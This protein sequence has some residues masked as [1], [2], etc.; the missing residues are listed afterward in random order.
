MN[1]NENEKAIN[2]IMMIGAK[3]RRIK[4]EQYRIGR[5][6]YV[7]EID[8]EAGRVRVEW[9]GNPTAAGAKTPSTWVNRNVVELI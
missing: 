9:I 8:N 6:G 5:K 7:I 4:G 3:V 1:A 2:P